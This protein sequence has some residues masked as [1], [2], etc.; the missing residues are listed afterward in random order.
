M[1]EYLCKY[2]GIECATI[3]AKVGHEALCT[4]NPGNCHVEAPAPETRVPETYKT[5]PVPEKPH[6]EAVA[7]AKA[8]TVPKPKA[9]AVH[10]GPK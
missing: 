10:K 8:H 9:K 5:T 2:C 7:K 3:Q 6:V 4:R 1:N